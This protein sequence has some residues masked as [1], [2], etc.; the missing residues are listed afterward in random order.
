M[1]GKLKVLEH[2]NEYKKIQQV[3]NKKNSEWVQITIE[4]K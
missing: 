1:K 4:Y 3:I 2:Y